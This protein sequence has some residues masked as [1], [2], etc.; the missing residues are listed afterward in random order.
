MFVLFDV[1][2]AQHDRSSGLPYC[3]RVIIP[4]K[5]PNAHGGPE[6]EERERLDAME[7]ELCEALT[8]HGIAC[9]MVGRLTFQGVREIV[10]QLHDY[11]SF[12]PPVGQWML[13]QNDYEIEVSEHEGWDFF[14][15]CIAPT[16]E[17]WQWIADRQVI[18][19]LI[20]SGANPDKP[21]QI[22]FFFNGVAPGLRQV[23]DAL[24][25]QGYESR[26]EEPIAADADVCLT[27]YLPLDHAVI[28]EHTL[29][30]LELADSYGVEYTGWGAGVER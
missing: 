15:D 28:F 20:E 3:A 22:E 29:H 14:R 10:F 13:A 4:I 17:G 26:E 5:S 30:H 27:K 21:H 11:E 18:E 23:V 2:A 9:R 25:E 16:R 24:R 19:R 7:D 6:G 12:R 1:D 8:R